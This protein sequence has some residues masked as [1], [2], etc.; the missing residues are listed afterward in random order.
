MWVKVAK[1]LLFYSGCPMT[2]GAECLVVSVP[3]TICPRPA[4]L[5]FIA[6][7]CMGVWVPARKMGKA[8]R[9]GGVLLFMQPA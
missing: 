8:C 7:P 1:H 2:M 5:N 3:L 9:F 6:S 4:A